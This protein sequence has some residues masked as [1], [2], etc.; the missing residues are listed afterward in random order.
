[1]LE[2][3]LETGK[4]Y[5]VLSIPSQKYPQKTEKTEEKPSEEQIE[6]T[7]K[8]TEFAEFWNYSPLNDLE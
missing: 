4:V 5:V 3:R 1:M 6:R 7:E 8:Q 2:K